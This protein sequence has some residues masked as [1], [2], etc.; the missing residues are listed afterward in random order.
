MVKDDDFAVIRRRI[1]IDELMAREDFPPWL[2][3][4]AAETKAKAEGAAE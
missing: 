3:E 2:D 4:A 1:G